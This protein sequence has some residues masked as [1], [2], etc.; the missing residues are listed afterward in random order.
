MSREHLC[1]RK[2]LRNSIADLVA[3]GRERA[4]L[5]GL[6]LTGRPRKLSQASKESPPF[7]AEES[8]EELQTLAESAGAVVE[9]TMLQARPAPDA[10]TLIG[11]GKLEELDAL[12][13][14]SQADT[15]LFDSDLTPTQLRNLERRLHC[16][17]LD[18]T[19]LILDIFAR[20]ARTREG[21]LQVELAQLNYLLPR[22]TGRGVEMSRLGGGIGTR[23]PGETQLETDRRRI[24]RRIKKL[25]DDLESVR[26]GRGTQRRQRQS[27]PLATI[28]LVGYTNAG[29][30]TLFNRLTGAEVLADA[31]MFA[32]LDP[33]VR[34]ITLPSNRKVLLS[35]TVGFIRNLPTTLVKAFRATLE[36]VVEAALLLHVVDVS[37]QHAPQQTAHVLKVLNDIG[38]GE[39][40]EILVLNKMDILPEKD[41]AETL[42]QRILGEARMEGK[43]GAIA[44]SARSGAGV[45]TL[46]EEMDQ[47]VSLDPV[48]HVRFRL[49]A[50]EGALLHYLHER[51]RVLATR[52]EGELCEIE[53]DTPESVKRRLT[54]YIVE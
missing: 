27:V 22:L 40:P 44:V 24:N 54:K 37:S 2:R 19:Q 10:A 8:L 23:G 14:A 17:V 9:A 15:V 4:I 18:R 43:A 53:A 30:S 13:T 7:S 5:V 32:T 21:Q 34:H 11:S 49:P 48:S 16:K 25:N 41:D 50:S 3:A 26:A 46:L 45:P 38:A 33:T 28:A 1:R 47:K 36:E 6:D 35:D 20:R 31:K 52:Y 39:T 51:A 12:V 42:A 29:K